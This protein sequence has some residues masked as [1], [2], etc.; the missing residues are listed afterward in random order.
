MRVWVV[1]TVAILALGG[2]VLMRLGMGGATSR[3]APPAQPQV[4]RPVQPSNP[5]E[6]PV[7]AQP[8]PPFVAALPPEPRPSTGRYGPDQGIPIL[9][10]HRFNLDTRNP[11]AI[12]PEGFR[13]VLQAL[14]D[15]NYCLL[16]L[17]D[18]ITNHFDSA[19]VGHKLVALTFDDGHFSQVNLI[20]GKLDPDSGLGV[21][22][23]VFPQARATF[24]LN[25]R[26]DGPP[27]GHDSAA[28]VALIR[29]LGLA[30]GNHT[31]SHAD[32]SRSSP[33]Q[34][35][36]QI[37]GVCQYFGMKSMLLAYPYGLSDLHQP[38]NDYLKTCTVS[39]AFDASLGYFELRGKIPH[40]LLA[41]L[42]G[43]PAFERLR[44]HLPR[45]SIHSLADLQR[46]VLENP[47]V[48][49]LEPSDSALA[50]ARG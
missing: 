15:Q 7:P 36:H 16:D 6:A 43:T 42:P 1:L 4:A 9:M 22:E 30:I 47:G 3:P 48:Y 18:Y 44:Y 41:P 23:S 33:A 34:I 35:E 28:K 50:K 10:F 24:F 12:T 46:D 29:Q 20:G 14:K 27:F 49:R 39:A 21:L 37:E 2:V 26:N 40:P 11:N 17:S 13:A 32:L 25:T 31:V 19:C 8:Q 5:S 45:I 38:V